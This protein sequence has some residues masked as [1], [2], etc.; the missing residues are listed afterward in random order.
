M[1]T[2]PDPIVL[3]LL[4]IAAALFAVIAAWSIGK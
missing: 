3:V 4:G 2:R 1:R